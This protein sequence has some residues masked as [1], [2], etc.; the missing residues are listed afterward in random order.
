M[1]TELIT[2]ENLDKNLSYF[3]REKKRFMIIRMVSALIYL[4]IAVAMVVV[5]KDYIYY[6]LIPI[7]GIIGYKMPYLS[8]LSKKSKNDLMNAHM[9]PNF[10]S[11][12]LAFIPSSV[13]VYQTLVA[14]V[15]DTKE[16]L[17]GALEDLI[18][19]IEDENR[20][21][22][23]LAFAEYVGTSESHMIMDMLYQFSEFGIKKESLKRLEGLI[24]DLEEN[25]MN[26]MIDKK[27]MGMD[28]LAYT[29]LFIS[30]FMLLGFTGVMLYHFYGNVFAAL[31]F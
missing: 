22:D 3:D 31:N 14:T 23:Y 29:P 27:M 26:E 10:L 24:Q 18:T 4:M 9:F 15:P 28:H 21:E 13:N 6:V 17:R 2:E 30:M 7:G 20:R 5:L 11:S 12:F 1:L 25:K 19:N 8:L 16:P